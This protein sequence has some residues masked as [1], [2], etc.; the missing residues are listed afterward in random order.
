MIRKMGGKKAML[1]FMIVLM[2][3]VCNCGIFAGAI[4]FSTHA[5]VLVRSEILGLHVLGV[6]CKSKDDDLGL[7]RLSYSQ[8]YKWSFSEAIFGSTLFWCHMSWTDS[9][10]KVKDAAFDVYDAK[11]NPCGRESSCEIEYHATNHGVMLYNAATG[12][13]NE[14]VVWRNL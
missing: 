1:S 7:H 9:D 11:K 10:R 2:L 6:H 13:R 14:V 5:T 8:E 4:K 3:V 12:E